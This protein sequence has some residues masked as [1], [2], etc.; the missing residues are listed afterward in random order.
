MTVERR[1]Y[2]TAAGGTALALLAGC[3]DESDTDEP[4]DDDPDESDEADSGPEAAVRS[5]LEAA[6]D[7]DDDALAEA[8]HSASFLYST[9]RDG[10]GVEY[11]FGSADGIDDFDDLESFESEVRTADASSDDILAFDGMAYVFD[12]ETLEDDLGDE[13]TALVWTEAEYRDPEVNGALVTRRTI[14]VVAT[15]AESDAGA[16]ESDADDDRWVVY[17]ISEL[18]E[19]ISDLEAA[20]EPPI[21]DED[22]DVVAEVDWD[23]DEKSAAVVLTDSPGRDAET[24][25]IEST[26]D[27][28][29]YE[30]DG[31]GTNA[32]AN[33]SATI[34]L[35]SDGDQIVVTAI[36]DGE[37]TVVH[38]VRFEP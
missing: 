16:P 3:L 31:E 28:S 34:S 5:Y 13:E 4:T 32:W 37:E 38:R 22:D 27:G 35:H 19:T 17:W 26:I 12:E 21:T 10:S 11:P 2:L 33:S 9:A 29:S 14:W 6:G 23:Y 36:D 20:F 8:A 1:S 30:F 15:D 24:V 25:R 7:Q 18:T